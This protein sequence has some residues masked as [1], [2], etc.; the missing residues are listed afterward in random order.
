MQKVKLMNKL[1][2]LI[3][4]LML[5]IAACEPMTSSYPTY[6][7]KPVPVYR[8]GTA[9]AD[10]AEATQELR[11]FASIEELR[12]FLARQSL[13][14]QMGGYG[15]GMAIRSS[16]GKMATQ[17]VGAMDMAE[18][19]PM[20]SVQMQTQAQDYSVTNVQYKEVDEADFVK[21][22]GRYIYTIAANKLVIVDAYEGENMKTVSETRVASLDEEEENQW[23][24]P[25]ARELFVDGD[26]LVLLV[27]T[28]EPSF[29]FQRYD[30]QPQE[31]Y[32][33]MTKAV[34]FDVSDRSNPKKSE[35]FEVSGA[36]FQSRLI[37][38]KMI[39][40]TQDS[41]SDGV[42]INEPMVKRAGLGLSNEERS[43][44]NQ[45]FD[46]KPEILYFDN[47]EQ[48][49]QFNT[50]TSID[51]RTG[52][53]IDA[54]TLMLGYSNTLMVSPENL[55]IAYQKQRFWRW[56]PWYGGAQ[57]ERARFTEVILP[58]VEGE[59]KA[60][61][62]TILN[63]QL[64]EQEEW[65][66]IS[67]ELGAFFQKIKADDE[68]TDQ[69]EE[70]FEKIADAVEEYD[71]KKALEESRTVV[72][73]IAIKDGVLEYKA[74]GEVDGNLL[75]QWSLDDYNGYL[76]L[77]TTVNTW[78]N[79]RVQYNNVYVL[80]GDMKQVGKV[81]G[82]AED[83]QIYSTRFMGDRLYMVTFRQTDPF[84]VI[85]L[86]DVTNPKVLG[87]LK[88]PGFSNYLHPYDANH[89]IGVG[90][91]TEEADWGGVVTGGIKLALFDV[92]DVSKPKQVGK[93]EIGGQGS[94]SEVLSD[95]KAFLFNKETGLLVLPVTKVESRERKNEYLWSNKIWNGAY[96][97][98]VDSSGFKELGRVKHS[99]STS[100]YI[101]WR[102]QA[103][104]R[105]SLYMDDNLYTV[106]TLYIKA[107]DL[108]N[109]LEEL[110]SLKLPYKE[111]YEYYY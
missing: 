109:D 31:T 23:M 82:I 42:I 27:Q 34:I 90:K 47:P 87:Q 92:S 67:K 63:E 62:D 48:N 15:E 104:V 98:R 97:F 73:K 101:N 102:D 36:Y 111:G 22:D 39:L 55:F 81:T 89:I 32:R 5:L 57:Y 74:K 17:S 95:H 86:S 30:I 59:L 58:L 41:V 45:L 85:D 18:S 68:L 56:G 12:E 37:D 99:Q 105:R 64:S 20:P 91:E 26:K 107:N 38:G 2:T 6:P 24:A 14:Q 83:E 29:Y 108:S 71:T 46:F 103:T 76:R 110:G 25:H 69:Y 40:V 88:I 79:Q 84:F 1:T 106:S 80:D 75:N 66:Q 35:E 11:T 16:I 28:Q 96:V 7:S 72:H 94:N 9:T 54:K 13:V 53:V 10:L 49:Y 61:I 19:A 21:N 52:D 93:V 70:M 3:L 43:L 100:D 4:A 78:T 44:S 33:Q 50:I 8:P 65:A 51:V 60:D 77:A